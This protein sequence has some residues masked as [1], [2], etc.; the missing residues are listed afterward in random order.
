MKKWLDSS[1]RVLKVGLERGGGVCR[2]AQFLPVALVG[3][4]RLPTSGVALVGH[5]VSPDQ[6]APSRLPALFA[7]WGT[8]K[9]PD[10]ASSRCRARLRAENTG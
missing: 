3:N 8:F 7:R 9:P 1:E 2:V 10:P 5:A 4:A 6:A